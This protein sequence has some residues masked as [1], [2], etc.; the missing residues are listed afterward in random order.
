MPRHPTSSREPARPRSR[1]S[2]PSAIAAASVPSLS[3]THALSACTG[4]RTH[5]HFVTLP[6][7]NSTEA[8]AVL[9]PVAVRKCAGIA[10][11][12]V[13]VRTQWRPA[14][15]QRRGDSHGYPHTRRS[16]SPQRLEG[17]SVARRTTRRVDHPKR[18]VCPLV[19]R[20][21][22]QRPSAQTV[23]RERGR[24][25]VQTDRAGPRTRP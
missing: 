2:L 13:C 4:H 20:E 18:V 10:R 5:S 22:R 9:P 17:R 11:P 6:C 1:A 12:D 19:E 3:A 7:V 16:S 25:V 23:L 14:S 21:H 8:I 15:V 24:D